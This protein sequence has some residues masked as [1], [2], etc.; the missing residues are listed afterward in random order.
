MRYTSVDWIT[1]LKFIRKTRDG[2]L[3]VGTLLGEPQIVEPLDDLHLQV[4][5]HSTH[6]H[7]RLD[8]IKFCC[9]KLIMITMNNVG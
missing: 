2:L 4:I 7:V 6:P 8:A 1:Y 9:G 3:F 5:R